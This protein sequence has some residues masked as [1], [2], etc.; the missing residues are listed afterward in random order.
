MLS[1]STFHM[2]IR[3]LKVSYQSIFFSCSVFYFSCRFVRKAS[4]RWKYRKCES[5]TFPLRC[6][7]SQAALCLAPLRCLCH[8]QVTLLSKL[9]KLFLYGFYHVYKVYS[10]R[11]C[12]FILTYF[13]LL[14][15]YAVLEKKRLNC[16]GDFIFA[17]GLQGPVH[18]SVSL[19]D[20]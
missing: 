15:F 4:V 2:C 1:L 11:G 12:R 8:S 16:P 7:Y 5:D 17:Y 9:I 20:P 13:L 19:V 18:L 3:H 14:M 10:P 6:K